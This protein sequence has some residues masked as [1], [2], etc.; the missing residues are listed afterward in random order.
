VPGSACFVEIHPLRAERESQFLIAFKLELAPLLSTL[1]APPL[2]IF[3]TDRSENSFPRQPVQADTTF[4]TLTRF[5]SPAELNAFEAAR[6]ASTQWRTR[7]AAAL[8]PHLA[9]PAEVLRLQPTAR[10]ALR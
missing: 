1:G 10:S 4:V 5:A 8:Q 6:A 3:I 9:A 7:F 2:A